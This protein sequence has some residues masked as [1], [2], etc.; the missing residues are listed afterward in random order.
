MVC[1][2]NEIKT[3]SNDIIPEFLLS[4]HFRIQKYIHY[5]CSLFNKILKIPIKHK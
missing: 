4:F 5:M 1:K 3:Y 2:A